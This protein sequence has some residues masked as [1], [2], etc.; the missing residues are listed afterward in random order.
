MTHD[1]QK[2]LS[3]VE[4]CT[5]RLREWV[6]TQET[7]SWFDWAKP[8]T[9]ARAPGRLDVMGGIADYSGSLVL[10][11]PISES[12]MVA[13]QPTN[14]GMVRIVSLPLD[15]ETDLRRYE[16]DVA[17]LQ[18]AAAGDPGRLASRLQVDDAG[19]HWA[20]YIAGVFPVLIRDAGLDL[21]G[22][23][24]LVLDSR[25][26]EGKGVSSSAAI[27]VATLLAVA[28]A[29]DVDLSPEAVARLCQVVEHQVAGAPCGIMDQMAVTLGQEN[30]L[31]ALLCRPAERVEHLD[32][33][34]DVEV[35]GIDSGERH[36]VAG[37]DYTT[38]RTA[39]FM[40]HRILM[41]HL[42]LEVSECEAGVVK[43]EN[44]PWDG[45]LCNIPVAD[46]EG[47]WRAMLPVSMR[48]DEFLSRYHGT[49]DPVTRV[50]PDRDYAVRACAD[51]P[52][53]E[54]AR[55]EEFCRLLKAPLDEPAKQRLGQLM[56]STHDGYTACG[57]DS[58]G[59]SKLVQW[60]KEEGGRHGLYGAK[61]TGGG[62]GGT[63]AVLAEAGAGAEVRR[64][65]ERYGEDLAHPVYLFA[66]S[67]SGACH[68]GS[69]GVQLDPT[70]DIQH[71]KPEA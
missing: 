9:L 13:V 39:A 60:V 28:G 35:W 70:P 41:H 67:S 45:Y 30:R 46:Y 54:T 21:A 16:V 11:M 5:H 69:W 42:G 37:A 52:I 10:E 48:G 43:V 4:A 61:I 57:L 17:A 6:T 33:P 18:A 49:I 1:E 63:V 27:E 24:R 3:T 7:V 23:C 51:H 20:S 29:F 15:D 14:D 32:L 34:P 59:T 71:P 47:N 2:H 22:G 55:V 44:D 58:P 36:T 65:A 8:I 19:Q 68:T 31:M 40:G 38:V 25:V 66:G 56:L 50:D 62:S 12:A 64:L 26:P 53:R